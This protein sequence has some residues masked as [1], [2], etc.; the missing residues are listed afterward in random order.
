MVK[1]RLKFTLMASLM[2]IHSELPQ[3]QPTLTNQFNKEEISNQTKLIPQYKFLLENICI[4]TVGHIKHTSKNICINPNN[5]L[6]LYYGNHKQTLL[7][8]IPE[9]HNNNLNKDYKI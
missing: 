8:I 7:Y 5:K 3:V 9:N 1:N 4:E 2:N 6:H